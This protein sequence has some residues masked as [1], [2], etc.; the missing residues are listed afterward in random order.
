[1]RASVMCALAAVLFLQPTSRGQSSDEAKA[2]VKRGIKAMGED[3]EPQN[4]KG[5]KI[6]SKGTLEIMGM[7]VP[8]DSSLTILHPGKFR[9]AADLNIN[10]MK[11]SVATV[12]DGKIAWIEIGGKTMK[13]DGKILDEIKDVGRLL[14][15]AKLKSLLT[16]KYDLSVIGEVKVN[17][18]PAVGIRVSSKGAKD[19]SLFF[20]KQSGVIAKMERQGFDTTSMQEVQEDRIIKSYKDKDG[21]KIPRQ[22]TILHDGNKFLDLEISEYEPLEN[23][24]PALFEMPK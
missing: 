7:S 4:T 12:F 10:N 22:V 8:I 9:E 13:L 15:V 3:K 20:D 1:M 14:Q 16:E 11:I 2:I 5:L 21:R 24:D 17:E 18:K 23:V 6:V 19:I